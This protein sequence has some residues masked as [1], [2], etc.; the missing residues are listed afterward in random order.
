MSSSPRQAPLP[1]PSVR[2]FEYQHSGPNKPSA[3]TGK[4][5]GEGRGIGGDHD[6]A[7]LL[8]EARAQGI[9]EGLQ[10][11]QQRTA[12]QTES[13]VRIAEAIRTFQQQSSDYYGRVEVELVHLALAIAGKILHRE[14]Q[15]DRMLIAA[16]AKV[17][18]EKLQRGTKVTVHVHPTEA[19]AWKDYF[20]IHLAGWLNIEVATDRKVD[21][22]NCI[23]ET[24]LGE[25]ELGI[26]SQLKEVERGFFDLLAQRPGSK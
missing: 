2:S 1:G 22:Q 9:Q 4:T 18:L 10:Q 7:R 16:L 14:A 21:A 13:F 5:S 25:T 24:E 20:K 11:V 3:A 12:E 8:A 17:A 15:V 23:L 6:L 26:E 19:E